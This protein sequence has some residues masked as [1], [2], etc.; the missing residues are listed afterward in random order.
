MELSSPAAK[1]ASNKASAW[2][3]QLMSSGICPVV[4]DLRA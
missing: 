1:E 2:T 4:P 3:F